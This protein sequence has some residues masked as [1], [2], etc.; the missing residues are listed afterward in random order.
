MR[1]LLNS[2]LTAVAVWVVTLISW[3]DVV[4][5]G[6]ESDWWK[7]A[8][9]FLVIGMVIAGMNALVRPLLTFL[10]LPCLILTL[11]LFSLLISWAILWLAS[12]FT[13]IIPGVELTLGDFWQTFWA[14]LVLAIVTAILQALIPGAGQR[15]EQ[16]F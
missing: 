15:R 9:V 16:T 8:L 12:W 10:A 4:V 11:G 3:F 13:G 6:G 5:E 1:F 14:A 2:A 7:R